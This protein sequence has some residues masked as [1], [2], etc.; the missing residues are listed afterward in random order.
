MC[1]VVVL[2]YLNNEDVQTL[3]NSAEGET[4]IRRRYVILDG[5]VSR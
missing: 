5:S 3:R 1:S 2:A 4:F